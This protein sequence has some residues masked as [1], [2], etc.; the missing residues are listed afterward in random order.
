M[1]ASP[2]YPRPVFDLISESARSFCGA[3]TAA[4]SLLDGDLLRLATDAGI[5][6]A[7]RRQEFGRLPYARGARHGHRA[8]PF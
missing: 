3:E 8:W 2:G 7:R 6:T 1:S 5:T 4:M